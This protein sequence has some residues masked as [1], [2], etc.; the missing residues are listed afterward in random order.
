MRVGVMEWALKLCERGRRIAWSSL[1]VLGGTCLVE[2]PSQ[3]SNV[4]P[5]ALRAPTQ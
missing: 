2:T 1:P 3:P 4:A 5:V